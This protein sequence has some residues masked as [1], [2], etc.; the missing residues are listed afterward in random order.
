MTELEKPLLTNMLHVVGMRQVD[1]ATLAQCK[2][3]LE[4]PLKVLEGHLAGQPYLLGAHFT[5]ADLNVAAV[6]A[7]AKAGRIDLSAYPKVADWLNRC[8]S[9]PA[10]KG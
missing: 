9:R 3:D 1:D 4:R 10:F 6:M 2:A 5:V 7:W 8:T